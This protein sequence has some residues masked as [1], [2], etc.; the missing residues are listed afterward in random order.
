MRRPERGIILA[1]LIVVLIGGSNF[2]AVRFS[3]RELAP[4]WGASLRFFVAGSLLLA[5]SVWRRI[6]LPP[7]HLLPQVVFFG[8]VNFGLTYAFAYWGLTQAPA[9][10]GSTLVAL[11]PLLTLF[12]AVALGMERF[13]MSGLVGAL[14]SLAGVAVVF[15]DQLRFDISPAALVALLLNALGIATGTILLK[16]LPRTHPIGTNAVAM[17][18]GAVLLLALAAITRE[19]A[20]L[21]TRPDTTLAFL[22]L[23]TIGSAGL[24]GGIIYL[25]Q[26]WTASASAY[27][28]VLFP[29][30]TVALGAALAGESVSPQ[31]VAGAALVMLGTYVGAL[32]QTRR[33]ARAIEQA[34]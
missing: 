34:A 16:R 11:G 5:F 21:P 20:A 6:P 31:F 8:T 7:R 15:S 25:V 13:R 23:V 1:F 4:F 18:P 12:L 17:F 22:Y 9:A 30:V 19:P 32:L 28:T 14:I 10:V 3:N 27:T 29:I 26:R 24:F 33:A 2:V